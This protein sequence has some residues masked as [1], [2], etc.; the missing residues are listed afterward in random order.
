MKL[1]ENNYQLTS[2][3][4][5]TVIDAFLT[6]GLRAKANVTHFNFLKQVAGDCWTGWEEE[7]GPFSCTF[8]SRE[9]NW[10]G[11]SG[12]VSQEAPCSHLIF[13]TP[14][15]GSNIVFCLG[16][17]GGGSPP[18]PCC[19]PRVGKFHKGIFLRRKFHTSN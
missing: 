11:G 12:W 7:D 15:F 2:N 14:G 1:Y 5:D 16:R 6:V 17:V 4:D 9:F 18:P 13:L 8:V 3:M 19:Y 10:G